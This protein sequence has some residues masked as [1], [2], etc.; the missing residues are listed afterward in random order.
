MEFVAGRE[1]AQRGEML[2][3]LAP[4]N[5]KMKS[6]RPSAERLLARFC[7]LHFL[8]QRTETQVT[9]KIVEPVTPVQ[10][11]ILALLSVPETIYTAN[12]RLPLLNSFD[13]S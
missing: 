6:A 3:G 1:L 11:R 8:G 7:G 9:G 13:S 5:P 12:F 2:A 4:G 10:R